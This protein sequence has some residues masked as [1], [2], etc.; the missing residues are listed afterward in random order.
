MPSLT[1]YR[2]AV[3][4]AFTNTGAFE[5]GVFHGQGAY[6]WASGIS[7]TG[8]WERG[9]PQGAGA[10][11]WPDGQ[12]WEGFWNAGRPLYKDDAALL[13]PGRAEPQ[14]LAAAPPAEA[15]SG[16]DSVEGEH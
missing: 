8:N 3:A 4:F 9:H 13:E 2:P 1:F 7:Y 16:S 15:D 11:T 6:Y 10:M 12:Q 5:N 14:S